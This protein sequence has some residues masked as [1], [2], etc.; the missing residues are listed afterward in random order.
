MT[1]PGGA[2]KHSF[3]FLMQQYCLFFYAFTEFLWPIY[4][5][6]LVRMSKLEVSNI[7]T[8]SKKGEN[9]SSFFLALSSSPCTQILAWLSIRFSMLP[10]LTN[11]YISYS[12]A[13]F[14]ANEIRT[15][16][17]IGGV[18]FWQRENFSS[19]ISWFY[20]K[21]HIQVLSV[22]LKCHFLYIVTKIYLEI[23]IFNQPL[24][25]KSSKK[26]QNQA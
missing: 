5:I 7:A 11:Q 9:Q 10:N 18:L 3:I 24:K 26:S 6:I 17:K 20:N 23:W 22:D 15:F 16:F 21:N 12:M 4:L 25:L 13:V 1:R 14:S 2:Y 19:K 8:M